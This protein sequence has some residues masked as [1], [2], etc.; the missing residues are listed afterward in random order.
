MSINPVQF[1]LQGVAAPIIAGELAASPEAIAG[2]GQT[3]GFADVVAQ[4]AGGTG[5][6]GLVLTDG[7]AAPV[8]AQGRPL[9]Q[10][11]MKPDFAS[12]DHSAALVEDAALAPLNTPVSAA[13]NAPLSAQ[14]LAARSELPQPVPAP[15]PEGEAAPV[16]HPAS[17][18]L[19]ALLSLSLQ[20]QTV[21]E[22]AAPAPDIQTADEL[23]DPVAV[24]IPL[25]VPAS[26][27]PD[28]AAPVALMP[29]AT[30]EALEAPSAPA[31]P[32]EDGAPQIPVAAA[33]LV[34]SLNARTSD[35]RTTEAPA[36]AGEPAPAP[37]ESAAAP[38]PAADAAARPA[39]VASAAVEA[40]A[41][42]PVASAQPGD[43]AVLAPV[44]PASTL[45]EPTQ[46]SAPQRPV[47]LVQ[48][49]PNVPLAETVGAHIVRLHGQGKTEFTLRMDPPE[50]GRIDVKLE[51]GT[52]KTVRAIVA[53]ELPQTL[54]LLQRDS[55][56]L[57]RVLADAGLKADTGSLSFASRDSNPFASFGGQN[58]R[59]EPRW[60]SLG[61]QE[62]D[63]ATGTPLAGPASPLR[64]LQRALDVMA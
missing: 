45:T 59:G 49:Q 63:A 22:D 58:E 23:P 43:D 31:L 33:P 53:A 62:P 10:S 39:V 64:N 44:S 54:D 37:R 4:L 36:L 16:A 28:D 2:E 47:V 18:Q 61:A 50:L 55:R 32:A 14:L 6:F 40:P 52:D 11:W 1:L 12:L 13:F 38:V 51:M 24:V 46:Q 56:T 9:A 60:L 15:A 30:A 7:G 5:E 27:M 25:A 21:T 19:T 20:A 57:E 48:A 29:T 35:A 41:P 42:V 34:N 17:G 8:P 26:Q 3:P